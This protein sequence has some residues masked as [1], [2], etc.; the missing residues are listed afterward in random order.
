MMN[1]LGTAFVVAFGG[2]IAFLDY[3]NIGALFVV[4]PLVTRGAWYYLAQVVPS[5]V[6]R[7]AAR[8]LIMD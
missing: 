4:S 2:I 3:P 1:H 7:D 8:G 5:H 6:D